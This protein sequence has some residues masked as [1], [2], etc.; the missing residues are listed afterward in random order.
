MSQFRPV[1][2]HDFVFKEGQ[3]LY[4]SCPYI[5]KNEWHPFTIS[6][7]SG[8]LSTGPRIALETGEEVIEVR[9]CEDRTRSYHR[10]ASSIS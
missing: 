10:F 3:Y 1:Y 2:K 4:L 9:G 6:S 5:N 8:D 7:A